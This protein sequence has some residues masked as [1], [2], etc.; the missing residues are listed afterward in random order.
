M[1]HAQPTL[2]YLAVTRSFKSKGAYVARSKAAVDGCLVTSYSH[3]RAGVSG[4]HIQERCHRE[5]LITCTVPIPLLGPPSQNPDP[6]IL[7]GKRASNPR[8]MWLLA[9]MGESSLLWIDLGKKKFTRC[10]SIYYKNNV[11]KR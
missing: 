9:A 5:L 1:C 3:R 11:N 6:Q 7:D 8:S 10:C 2:T 4:V